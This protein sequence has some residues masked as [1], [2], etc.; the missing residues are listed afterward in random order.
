MASE[1]I[2]HCGCIDLFEKHRPYDIWCTHCTS[3]SKAGVMYRNFM[4]CM[5]VFGAPINV[6]YFSS[7]NPSL[8]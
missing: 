3:D 2:E 1:L 4:N 8:I 5:G 6:C 7:L